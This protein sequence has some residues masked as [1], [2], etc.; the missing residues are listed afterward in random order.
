MKHIPVSDRIALTMGLLMSVPSLLLAAEDY[1]C[2][3]V[4]KPTGEK[5]EY[6]FAD[7]EIVV[8]YSDNASSAQ[9]DSIRSAL[10]LSHI[11]PVS[12]SNKLDIFRL[13]E[14]LSPFS[15]ATRLKS[16]SGTLVTHA[17]PAVERNGHRGHIFP[18]RISVKFVPGLLADT[19]KNLLIQLGADV[20]H[21]HQY[22][23]TYCV[24]IPPSASVFH[25]IRAFAERP[26]VHSASPVHSGVDLKLTG[27]EPTDQSVHSQW[28]LRSICNCSE[29]STGGPSVN[30]VVDADVDVWEGG[31][32]QGAWDLTKGDSTVVVAL[33]DPNGF[34]LNHPDLV[35]ASEFLESDQGYFTDHYKTMQPLIPSSEGYRFE[36]REPENDLSFLDGVRLKRVDRHPDIKIAVTPDGRLVKYSEQI[37]PSSAVD[38]GGVN[39]T[40]SISVRDG[41][42]LQFQ[43]GD[44]LLLSFGGLQDEMEFLIEHDLPIDLMLVVDQKSTCEAPCPGGGGSI[45]AQVEDPIEPGEW[46]DVVTSHPRALWEDYVVPLAGVVTDPVDTLKIRLVWTDTHSIDMAALLRPSSLPAEVR[47]LPLL[48]AE[49]SMDGSV[50]PQLMHA[51]SVFAVIAPGEA[52]SLTF[53]MGPIPHP[54]S[55]QEFV[56]STKGYYVDAGGPGGSRAR[57]EDMGQRVSHGGRGGP[58][59]FRE[60]MGTELVFSVPRAQRASLT[61]YDVSGRRVRQLYDEILPAGAH[62]IWWDGCAD[63]RSVLPPGMYFAFYETQG[64]R[65]TVKIAII[66]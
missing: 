21:H 13:P 61:I 12:E 49:H 33:I 28:H 20:L 3:F 17:M 42:K 52:I 53:G 5:E 46:L 39:Y 43:E 14:G 29:C 31:S 57:P 65:A 66:K 9:T 26:E 40:E 1:E 37:H 7:D 18:D 64:V 41:V 15:L 10:S 63:N 55:I 58:N 25:A 51:D 38:D 19:R 30:C 60:G 34:D 4:W 50:K 32:G 54:G 62:P 8:T 35:P 36:I 11:Y 23:D 16:S 56:F 59:P 27:F 47:D 22:I 2:S 6:T 24:S 45:I 44:W 48:V